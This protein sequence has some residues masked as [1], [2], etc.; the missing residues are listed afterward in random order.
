M[1]GAENRIQQFLNLGHITGGGI[2][3]VLVRVC[4]QLMLG[5]SRDN[6]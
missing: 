3:M 1:L 6:W 2:V 5:K 4:S